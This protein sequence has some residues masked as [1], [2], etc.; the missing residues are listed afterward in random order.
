MRIRFVHGR[1][2]AEDVDMS[3]TFESGGDSPN[4]FQNTKEIRRHRFDSIAC[5]IAA[6]MRSNSNMGGDSHLMD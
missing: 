5:N 4:F 1:Q 2:E 3:P 6:S